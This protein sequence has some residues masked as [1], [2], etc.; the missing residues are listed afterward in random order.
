MT[1]YSKN[2]AIAFK[3]VMAIGCLYTFTGIIG[4]L[5]DNAGTYAVI[6]EITPIDYITC[7]AY[8]SYTAFNDKYIETTLSLPC[9]FN[10]PK[11][12]LL[13]IKYSVLLPENPT[14]GYSQDN[15]E[16][17]YILVKV[18]M[19]LMLISGPFVMY[20]ERQSFVHSTSKEHVLEPSIEY[21]SVLTKS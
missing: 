16:I 4:L 11:E 19:L 18:G 2:I 15:Y 7:E 12:L 17:A 14:V 13:P 10:N 9:S 1:G 6:Q 20:F 5:V 21:V 3:L 8:I